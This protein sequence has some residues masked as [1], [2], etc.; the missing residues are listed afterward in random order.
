MGL[1]KTQVYELLKRG[2]AALKKAL[3]GMGINDAQY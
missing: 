3:E 1:R 2:K